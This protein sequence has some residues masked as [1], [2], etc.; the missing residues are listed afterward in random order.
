MAPGGETLGEESRS[1]EADRGT[2][3]CRHS[4]P[5]LPVRAPDPLFR[6]GGTVGLQPLEKLTWVVA[7]QDQVVVRLSDEPLLH[8]VVEESVDR[9]VVARHVE[10]PAGFRVQT[11]LRPRHDL[12][13]LL[14]RAQ[15]AW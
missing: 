11:E 4:Y 2:A 12:E 8:G 6:I 7:D 10:H 5:S 15:T 14:Q 9:V 3:G 1:D 13:K